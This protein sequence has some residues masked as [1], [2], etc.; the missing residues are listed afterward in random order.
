MSIN[1]EKLF[2]K[3][4]PEGIEVLIGVFIT[5]AGTKKSYFFLPKNRKQV[6]SLSNQL[7]NIGVLIKKEGVYLK[8]N[9]LGIFERK[10]RHDQWLFFGL[11]PKKSTP[12]M[13]S[14]LRK[15]IKG[16]RNLALSRIKAVFRTEQQSLN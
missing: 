13:A 10:S 14:L 9:V 3:I 2:D 12:K 11:M 15:L 7:G 1:F 8:G 16:N 4:K 5:K 6:K